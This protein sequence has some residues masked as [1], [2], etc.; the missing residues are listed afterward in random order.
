MQ[1]TCRWSPINPVDPNRSSRLLWFPDKRVENTLTE[2]G[3]LPA[4]AHS[5]CV[6]PGAAADAALFHW[7]GDCCVSVAR[8]RELAAHTCS[9]NYANQCNSQWEAADR[10]CLNPGLDLWLVDV[11]SAPIKAT[12]VLTHATIDL[13]DPN[14]FQTLSVNARA[15]QLNSYTAVC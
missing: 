1:F 10:D 12:Q 14:E 5:T 11:R 2:L 7:N 13:K 6:T 4:I 9:L 15:S 8:G 3:S